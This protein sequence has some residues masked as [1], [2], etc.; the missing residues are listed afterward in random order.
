MSWKWHL[1]AQ[2]VAEKWH[3]GASPDDVFKVLTGRASGYRT[4]VIREFFERFFVEKPQ[5]RFVAFSPFGWVFLCAV[6]LAAAV[7]LMEKRHK[8]AVLCCGIAGIAVCLIFS[9]SLL[10]SYLFVFEEIEAVSLASFYRYL[11]SGILTMVMASFAVL[12]WACAQ[13]PN[14]AAT[15]SAF[16]P[17]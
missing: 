7:L 16:W 17:F 9:A 11:N 6:L 5:G 13:R 4:D 3:A 2:G 1:A 8:K 14:P 15:V 12:L 10:Y